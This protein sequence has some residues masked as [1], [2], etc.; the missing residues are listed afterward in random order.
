MEHGRRL[1]ALERPARPHPPVRLA[2]R[3][4]SNGQLLQAPAAA[5][6]LRTCAGDPHRRAG[7]QACRRRAQA[8]PVLPLQL[9]D[10]NGDRLT[11]VVLVARNGIYA[12]AQA[13]ASASACFRG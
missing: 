7:P 6:T 3:E 1:V 4:A 9:M 12:W 2:R 5:C 8:P 13:R 11:D 10:F